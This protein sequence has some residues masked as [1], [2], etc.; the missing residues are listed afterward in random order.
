M[1]ARHPRHGL[2]FRQ[3]GIVGYAAFVIAGCTQGVSGRSPSASRAWHGG[4]PMALG[5]AARAELIVDRGGRI[6]VYLHDRDGRPMAIGSRRVT[7]TVVTPDGV[8]A[9]IP[10]GRIGSASETCFAAAIEPPVL[11]RIRLQGSY[12][13]QIRTE[14]EGRRLAGQIAV[15]GLA[16]GGNRG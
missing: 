14:V 4:R 11:D 5:P 12:R 15:T 13:L 16:T 3:L 10:L 1:S 9:E 6:E 7:A 8:G 2:S